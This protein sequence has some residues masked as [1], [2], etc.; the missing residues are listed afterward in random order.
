M[1]LGV[2][3]FG[4]NGHQIFRQIEN[5]PLA[6]LVAIAAI[7]PQVLPQSLN[8]ASDVTRYNS[9]EE[10][11]ADPKVELISLCSPRRAEQAE[12]AKRAMLAGKHVYAEKPCAL[13]E[14]DLDD[15]IATSQRTG[16]F[17]HEMA[18]T[19]FEQ[20]YSSMR[21]LVA[22]GV[23][24]QVVQVLA[25]KS[26]PWYDGRPQDENVDGGLTLQNGVH[27]MRFIEHVAGERIVEI[28]AV[29]T[30]LG[31]PVSGGQ[32]RMATSYLMR[33]ENGGVASAVANYLNPRGF[34]S[35]GNESLRIFGTLGM[36]EST[37][38]G[39]R[40]RLI[41][42]ER[43]HGSIILT[44]DWPEYFTLVVESILGRRK[45]P[46]TLEQALHPTRMVIRARAQRAQPGDAP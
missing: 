8:Q 24:G 44:Q 32:C 5:H 25:Q 16:R 17:F 27:A 10:L 2:A 42:G 9:F 20:P 7:D 43:D 35:W 22:D 19:A 46:L 40:T 30:T 11:L 33:L 23:I 37:D 29:E 12:Q 39:Q 21:Q 4:Q 36:M 13:T 3:L 45:M 18:G 26:Y 6:H 28:Q 31:N 1:K 34:G 41:I 15:L 14:E 38:G